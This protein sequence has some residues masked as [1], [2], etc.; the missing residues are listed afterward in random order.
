MFIQ[1]PLKCVPVLRGAA[2]KPCRAN[3][4]HSFNLLSKLKGSRGGGGKGWIGEGNSRVGMTSRNGLMRRSKGRLGR[5]RI[6]TAGGCF[7]KSWRKRGY[8]EWFRNGRRDGQNE[9]KEHRGYGVR[10]ESEGSSKP[11]HG[12]RWSAPSQDTYIRLTF[13]S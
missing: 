11:Q 4:T 7:G 13:I 9:V 12:V 5:N 10:K 1:M 6:E 8:G 3:Y 2:E